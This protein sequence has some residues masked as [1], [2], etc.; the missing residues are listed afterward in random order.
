MHTRCIC[1]SIGNSTTPLLFVQ[2][3]SPFCFE[4][5]EAPC[6][7]GYPGYDSQAS[8]AYASL[9]LIKGFGLMLCVIERRYLWLRTT[10]QRYALRMRSKVIRPCN[11]NRNER[12]A[13]AYV[14]QHTPYY[15]QEKQTRRRELR[16]CPNLFA[17]IERF[18]FFFVALCGLSLS[19]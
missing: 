16:C 17:Y 8:P 7:P 4:V 6:R 11:A 5:Q 1:V 13:K 15:L 3:A 10:R 12:E 2:R 9:L 19:H 18:I 14:S